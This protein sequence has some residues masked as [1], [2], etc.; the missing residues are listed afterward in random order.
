MDP[1]GNLVS[2]V[3]VSGLSISGMSGI[4]IRESTGEAILSSTNGTIY[5]VSGFFATV[6]P[7]SFEVIRGTYVAGDESSI[8][9]SDNVDLQI[10]R[11]SSDI[12]ARV[13]V[14]VNGT[15]MTEA[16]KALTFRHESSV[17]ARSDVTQT[18]QMFDYDLAI[19]ETLDTRLANRF[20]DL[21]TETI[22]EGDLSRFIE[23]GSGNM[24]ARIRFSSANPRQQFQANIDQLIWTVQ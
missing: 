22:I 4:D 16:P 9:S 13:E 6:F 2:D 3:D 10:R 12:Q 20:S 19:W 14:E 21:T 5:R 7:D 15:S 8:G 17:F 11:N 24:S 1:I 23:P 18:L